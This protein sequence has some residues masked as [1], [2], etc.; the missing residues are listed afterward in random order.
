MI[1]DAQ[2]TSWLSNQSA[3]RCILVEVDV[4]LA[5]T[6]TVV[7]RYLSNKAF[8]T[9]AA[10]TPANTAYNPRIK[11]GIKFTKSL[12]L[13]GS[14][15]TS[16]GD[17]ELTNVDGALDSWLLDYWTNRSLRIYVGDVAWARSDFR[18]AFSGITTGVAAKDR[19]KINIQLSDKLQRINTPIT[20]VVLG[21][22]TTLANTLRPLLF[23]EC[24][25]ISPLLIDQ[26]TNKYMVHQGAIERIIEVRDNGI[27]VS[28]TADLPNGM[29]TLVNQP[30]GT[31]T[32]SAQGALIPANLNY[33]SDALSTSPWANTNVSVTTA[34]SSTPYVN[35]TSN[36][37][38]AST[39]TGIHIIA[40]S[41]T[42]PTAGVATTASV[43]VKQGLGSKVALTVT[44]IP[45]G[46]AHSVVLD[47]A[48]GTSTLV[49]SSAYTANGGTTTSYGAV[50]TGNGWWRLWITGSPSTTAANRIMRVE[51]YDGSGNSSYT[52]DGISVMVYATGAQLETGSYPTAYS[53]TSNALGT[54]V[55]RNTISEI[56]RYII[57]NTSYGTANQQFSLSDLNI[58]SF[59]QFECQNRQPIG[60]YLDSKANILEE[61][62]GIAGSI[63]ASLSI[64]KNGLVSI[65]KLGLPQALL[66]TS[67]GQADMVE[68]SLSV[69]QLVPVIAGVVLGYCRNFTVQDTVAGGVAQTSAAMFDTEWLTVTRTDT[70]AAT[71]YNLYTTPTQINTNLVTGADA[72]IEATRRLN[73]FNVQR[74]IIK[75]TGFYSL[76]FENLGDPQT[77]T[78][79]RFGLSSGV[80]GQIISISVDFNSPHVD[81][82]V[83]V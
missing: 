27:P 73:I 28:F 56:A 37:I 45:S 64:D 34:S 1:T 74:R 38:I 41:I 68:K 8:V 12:S 11:T 78:N 22:T 20:T 57:T 70:T 69:A 24:H 13:D 32:V 48:S 25:N 51:T 15:S 46:S 72:T 63:G 40:N 10:D 5:G 80:T 43:F 62:N 6:S 65:V 23:G 33:S 53:L 81:F 29:F 67:V 19:T 2:F 61:V 16:Y 58:A 26:A 75:Y 50:S 31:I 42:G 47:F 30:Y 21:G 76:I 82:Q 3:I 52:G 71:N 18:L 4:G 55:Y 60:E 39:A 36:A 49:V 44:G 77:I 66:G 83:L 79:P 59:V 14:V 7:T 54:A 17:L 35:A 9:T